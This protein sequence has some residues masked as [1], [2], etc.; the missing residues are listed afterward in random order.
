MRSREIKRFGKYMGD[1]IYKMSD[2]L[3]IWGV[4]GGFAVS[5]LENWEAGNV[6]L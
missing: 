3:E 1:N 6:I 5:T 2:C 4:K